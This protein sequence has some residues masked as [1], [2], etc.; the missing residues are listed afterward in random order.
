M[1]IIKYTN[2]NGSKR[3]IQIPAARTEQLLRIV[4]LLNQQDIRYT[5]VFEE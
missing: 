3:N 5:H 2:G 4:S 1:H